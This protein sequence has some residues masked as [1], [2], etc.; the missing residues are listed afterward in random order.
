MGKDSRHAI[1]IAIGYNRKA[2]Y[3]NAGVYA[4]LEEWQQLFGEKVPKHLKEAKNK[5]Q[6]LE[7]K[8]RMVL[9]TMVTYDIKV[10]RSQA[11][12]PGKALVG[13]NTPTF[14]AKPTDV[15][16]WFDVKIKELLELREA[17]GTADSYK[18]SKSFYI[19]YTGYTVLDFGY[20]TK[21]TLYLIQKKAISEGGM[22]AGNVYRHARQLRAIFNMAI[23]ERAI[24][25]SIY[26]FHK[27][28]YM[29]PQT[30][31]KKKALS[32]DNMA[33]LLSYSPADELERI[34]LDF[35]LFSFFGNGM[36]M[37]DVAYLRFDDM[38]V[39]TLRFVRK[40][41]EHTTAQQKDIRV[42]ITT[43]MREVMDRQANKSQDGFI[44][45]IIR[46]GDTVARQR[47]DYRRFHVMVNDQLKN[48]CRHLGFAKPVTHGMSRYVFA[49]ALKQ[50][51]VSIDYI[52][53]AMGHSSTAVTE[54]YLNSFEDDIVSL[55]AEKL[56]QYS[57]IK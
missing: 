40:K 50:Q 39:N 49:N 8:I 53:E 21:E 9:S 3:V 20:F 6:A 57:S 27:R 18:N 25:N 15:F 4:N 36:N 54:H 19:K 11:T 43:E 2:D 1:K 17:L 24:D 56:R 33:L 48:I 47:I 23:Q 35:F 38:Y 26:P 31:K 37:K 30:T 12:M 55:H 14:A 29:I 7:S 16:Y 44:F 46:E 22:A 5:I 42:A 52:S 34:A 51:G 32:R 13:P 10:I 41:T 45:P 28:G